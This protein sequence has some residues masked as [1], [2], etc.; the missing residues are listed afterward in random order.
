[1]KAKPPLAILACCGMALAGSAAP[2]ATQD[3]F[4]VR[5]TGDLV[6]LCS[7][8]QADPLYTAAVNFC[9]GFVAGA[10]RVL[11]ETDAANPSQHLFCLPS[12]P[13]TRND[14]IAAFV[15]WAKADPSQMA[16]PAQDGLAAFLSR[17][18]PCAR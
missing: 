14:A 5:N 15:R 3:S 8:T 17:Q 9:Q 10:Y 2:A 12:P 6:D 7:A 4:L 16:Q 11:Q 13:P 18:Y 1:M